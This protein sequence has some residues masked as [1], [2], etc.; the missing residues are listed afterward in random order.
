MLWTVIPDDL[1]KAYPALVFVLEKYGNAGNNIRADEHDW[2][3]F[4]CIHASWRIH[5]DAKNV[6]EKV[7]QDVLEQIP[8]MANTIAGKY[9]FFVKFGG[10]PDMD[11]II[12]NE[13][14]CR[15]LNISCKKKLSAD[16]WEA[17]KTDCRGV[18]QFVHERHMMQLMRMLV[19]DNKDFNHNDIKKILCGNPRHTVA[20]R[21]IC[22]EV[23]EVIASQVH[24]LTSP[25][26]SERHRAMT[27]E[28]LY[29]LK[30]KMHL[31]MLARSAG[32]KIWVKHEH[33]E[34]YAAILMQDV[35]SI[36]GY[37]LTTKWDTFLP[38]KACNGRQATAA[39]AENPQK[40]MRNY[41]NNEEMAAMLLKSAGFKFGDHIQNK[42]DSERK[43]VI[44]ATNDY[45]IIKDIATD[46]L[47]TVSVEEFQAPAQWVKLQDDDTTE[48]T[49][50]LH[51][52]STMSFLESVSV[53]VAAQKAIMFNHL[54]LLAPKQPSPRN[55][56]IVVS[57]SK[58]VVLERDFSVNTLTLYPLTNTI[59]HKQLPLNSKDEKG[60]ASCW[61]DGM[62]YNCGGYKYGLWMQPP[63]CKSVID[64]AVTGDKKGV[65]STVCGKARSSK[66]QDACELPIVEPFWF[67]KFVSSQEEA[68]MIIV[69]NNDNFAIPLAT[70]RVNVKKGDVLKVYDD[71]NDVGDDG[72]DDD[73]ETLE[74]G[75]ESSGSK[76]Q[77]R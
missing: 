11:F 24:Q 33:I 10:G 61:T 77:R 72:D 36:T 55:F 1:A 67:L 19:E 42:D 5:Q 3:H 31:D 41:S 44:I 35:H 16:D 51:D 52:T 7:K 15:L 63:N 59:I 43:A 76:R 20:V 57:P 74:L 26:E 14:L 8:K 25:P 50:V 56:S 27:H 54:L 13:Q 48:T 49:K 40:S 29:E 37:K 4:R 66:K 46:V 28:E 22:D 75:G 6:F 53:S 58:G 69:R 62:E 39:P 60:L 21:A 71:I 9:E 30:T 2:Q 38:D 73:E 47:Q 45:I 32:K 23:A 17:L 34:T 65:L 68:N 70:N 64:K 18:E 12:A